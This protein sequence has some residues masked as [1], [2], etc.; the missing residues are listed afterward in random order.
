MVDG[1]SEVPRFGL[2]RAHTFAVEALDAHPV[3]VEVDVAR[4]LPDFRIV[5]LADAGVREAR[6]RVRAAIV[7]SGLCFPQAKITANL[8]PAD[9]RKVGSS[10]DLAIACA[11]LAASGQ[12]PAAALERLALFGEL[13]LDGG[14]RACHG[15]LAAAEAARRAELGLMAG[16]S[17][18]REA[19][20]IGG[21]SVTVADTLGAAVRVLGGGPGDPLPPRAAAAPA[22]PAAEDLE[23]SDVFGQRR[24]VEAMLVAAAGAHNVM[25]RGAPGTGKTMLAKHLPSILPPLSEQ[26][27][28]EVMRIRS[29]TAEQPLTQLP[30][31][32]PFRAPHHSVTMAG[33]I[34]GAGRGWVGEAVMAHRGVL[35]LD[36]L[37]EFARGPLEALRQPLEDGSVTIARARHCATYPAR[38]MLVAAANPCPCGYAGLPNRCRC[39]R[40]ARLRYR[41]RLSGPLLDRIDLFPQ[42][43]QSDPEMEAARPVC[44]SRAAR[45]MVVAARERQAA[46][47][48]GEGVSVNAQMD[49]RLLREHVRLDE[50]GERMLAAARAEGRISV[51]G[52]HRTLRVARTI[53]DLA[54]SERVASAHL[55]KALALGA[56]AAGGQA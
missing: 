32:R 8:A 21:L 26:E 4:G 39:S 34:G 38:F 25:L 17:R 52:Q 29:L 24:A 15:T 3:G 42:V 46:R 55:A 19:M 47:L 18:A 1:D 44:S 56:G 54:G 22:G 49:V 2:A 20:L 30:S 10:F 6:D 9:L 50:K 48:Q 11:V 33:L 12:A 37:A 35:F 36:E 31:V 41:D 45:R 27:A 28:L 7:N 23:L 13:G 40:D 53:A 51:R 43:V 14:V 16:S 5:G